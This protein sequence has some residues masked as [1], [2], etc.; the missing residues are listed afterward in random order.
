MNTMEHL[1]AD[2]KVRAKKKAR[3][4]DLTP[5][6]TPE[7]IEKAARNERIFASA[8]TMVDEKQIE[9][10]IAETPCPKD[11]TEAMR[12]AAQIMGRKGGKVRSPLKTEKCRENGKKGG[13]PRKFTAG[14][15]TPGGATWPTKEF[16][17][18][19]LPF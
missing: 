5:A 2:E 4:I 10:I 11:E 9:S 13:A 6:M 8:R 3:T 18:D 17:N 12:M 14:G 16:T 1:A 7:E 15:E 19:D